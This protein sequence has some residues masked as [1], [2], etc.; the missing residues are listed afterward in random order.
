MNKMIR[1]LL[2]GVAVL[3]LGCSLASAST[4]TWYNNIFVPGASGGATNAPQGTPTQYPAP[5]STTVEIPK[6]DQTGLTPNTSFQ[7]SSVQIV[8]NWAITGTVTVINIDTTS[9]HTF[10]AV[11]Q[12][13]L[14]LVG[15]DSTT[16][17]A[18]AISAA[19]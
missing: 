13:P 10:S 8:L 11:A 17:N 3:T 1:R 2:G 18:T 16:V 19:A 14:S 7:L 15:P 9:P 12:T 4:I 5:F 6:F